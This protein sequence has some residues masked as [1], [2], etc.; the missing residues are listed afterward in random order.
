[1]NY[2]C[3][4]RLEKK[5]RL[6]GIKQH[7]MEQR[8]LQEESKRREQREKIQRTTQRLE[9]WR[10]VKQEERRLINIKR[11]ERAELIRQKCKI[12]AEMA[13]RTLLDISLDW[14]RKEKARTKAKIKRAMDIEQEKQKAVERRYMIIK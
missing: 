12:A 2:N 8:L 3:N 10:L 14:K 4:S 5:E 7:I 6:V 11:K 1:M 9:M 13:H